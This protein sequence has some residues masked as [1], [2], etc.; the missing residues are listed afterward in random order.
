MILELGRTIPKTYVQLRAN[1]SQE[2]V[3][4]PP[5]Q[6]GCVTLLLNVQEVTDDYELVRPLGTGGFAKVYVGRNLSTGEDV[7]IKRIDMVKYGPHSLPVV[8]GLT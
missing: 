4:H 6:Q 8:D 1:Q 3:I 7:A 5:C 2:P